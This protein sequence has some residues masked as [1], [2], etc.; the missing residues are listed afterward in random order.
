MGAHFDALSA[1]ERFA[2]ADH[3]WEQ[4]NKLV[5]QSHESDVVLRAQADPDD[6]MKQ[7]CELIAS[8]PKRVKAIVEAVEGETT[9]RRRLFAAL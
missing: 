2:V 6:W 5:F 4:F 3:A 9:K 8:D 1:R 7:L